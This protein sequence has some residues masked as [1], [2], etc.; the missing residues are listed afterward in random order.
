MIRKGDEITFD[1]KYER[2]GQEA[3]KCFCGAKICRGWLG[4]EPDKE[5][6]KP[7][8]SQSREDLLKGMHQ[9]H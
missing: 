1:Y 2:Y 5:N 3:Q 8:K 7:G 4:G 9:Y 6:R